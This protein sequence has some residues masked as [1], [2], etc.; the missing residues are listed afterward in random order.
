MNKKFYR[1]KFNAK[2]GTYVA[3]S[4]LAK[5]HQ[6]DTSPRIKSSIQNNVRDLSIAAIE[7]KQEKRTL[8]QLVLALSTLMAVSPIYANVVVNN[9]AAAAHKGTVL[10]AGNAANVWI[11]APSASGV[12][13]NSYTQFDVNQNGVILNN[14]RGAATSQITKTSIAA[15]P[16][17][18]KGAAT[19]IVNEVISTNPSLLQGNLEVLGSKANVVIA[20][21][22]GITVNGGGFINANQVTLSTGA[23]AYNSDGSIKQHTVKQGA[24]TINPDAN[25]RGLGGNANN[26]V[27]LELLGRSIA[28][29]APVNATTINAVTGAN[30]IAADTGAFTTTT[31]TGTKPTVAI[32]VAQLG[33][34]Y[35]NS[36]YLYANEAGVGV[37]NAGII[38]AQN[39]VVLN[40]N[41]KITNTAT[42]TISST[43]KTQGLVS[44]STAGTGV[45]GD[46]NSSGSINSNSVINIDS[47]NDLNVN[48]KEIKI[49]KDGV[50]SSPLIINAKGNLNLAAN[51][52]IFNDSA[53][54]DLYIDAGNINLATNAGITSNRGSGSIQSQKDIVAAQGVK[55]IA[56]QDLNVSSKGKLALTGNVLQATVGSINLQADSSN[57]QGL[58]DVQKTSVN[59]GKDLNIYSAGDIT[60]KNLSFSLINDMTRLKNIN[61]YSEKNLVWQNEAK[62]L[63]K[64]AGKV[65]L[66]AKQGLDLSGTA[67][68]TL[69]GIVTAS[70]T[71]VLN[72]GLTSDKGIDL[73][74][75]QAVNLKYGSNLKA[76]GDI[77][78]SSLQGGIQAESLKV[79]TQGK[80]TMLAQK[81]VSLSSIQ[82]I[83]EYSY[84]GV[85]GTKTDKTLLNTNK[86]I[87]VGSVADGKVHIAAADLTS[88]NGVVALLGQNDITVTNNV[89]TQVVRE[90]SF[91][92]IVNSQFTGKSVSIE[93]KK[94]NIAVN[95]TNLTATGGNL[96]LNSVAGRL[97]VDQSTL[98]SKGNTELH[99]KDLLTLQGVTA[100]SDQHL[101]VSSGRTL[102]LNASY[103]PTT[104]VWDPAARTD[105]TAKGVLSLTATGNQVMQN[106]KLTGGAV[107][108]ETTNLFVK[109]GLVFNAVGNDLLKNDKKLNSLNGNLSIQT[110]GTTGLT[111]DP[112][113]MNLS[114]VGDIE[115]TSK[116]GALTL[117]GY[118][119]AK[120]SGSEQVV[121]LNTKTGGISLEGTQVNLQGSQLDAAKDVKIIASNGD[122]LIDG[123][124]NNFNN[125]KIN[126]LIVS[127][128]NNLTLAREEKK[129][130]DN[131]PLIITLKDEQKNQ[132]GVEETRLAS[133]PN[134]M[135]NLINSVNNKYGKITSFKIV[136]N[137]YD[138]EGIYEIFIDDAYTTK[139]NFLENELNFFGQALNGYEHHES[140]LISNNGNISLISLNGVSLSGAEVVAMQ[141]SVNIEAHGPLTQKYMTTAQKENQA[142]TI[143]ASIIIDGTQDFYDKGNEND[144]NYNF[145]TLINPSTLSG[146]KG[147]N[148]KAIGKTENDNLVLQAT[149]ITAQNG[150]VRIEAN[151]NIVFDSA[152]EQSYDRSTTSYTKKSWGGMKKK[153]VTINTENNNVDAASVDITGKNIFIESK[154]KSPN[155]SIDIYSGSFI[156]D[157]GKVSIRSGGNLNFF[158]VEESSTSKEDVT[159]KSSFA[160]IKY[161]KSKSN[162]TRTQVTEMPASL[163]ADYIG[164]KSG[165]DTRLV[166]TE[167]EYLKDATIE[168]GRKL[169]LIAAK[170]KITDIVKKESNSIV[171]QSM[172]DKGSINETAKLPS[173]NGPVAPAFIAEGGLR[174]QVPVVSGQNNDVIAEVIK[175]S[176]QPGNEYLK[177]LVARKDVNWDAV[178]LAQESWDYKSQGLTGAGA[179]I[180]AIIVVALTYG[181][182]TAAL[183]TT[184]TAAEGATTVTVA[185]T[186]FAVGAGGSVTTFGGA[187]M[188]TTVGGVSTFTATG[189]MVNAALTTMATKSSISLINNGG[190]VGKTL[191]ELGSKDSVKNLAVTL[192]TVG[193][194]QGIATNLRIS[195]DA[196]V[197]EL[198]NRMATGMIKGVGSTLIDSAINGR[199]LSE[200]LENALL[201]GLANSLQAPLAG[202][203]GDT[204][205][206]SD[207]AFVSKV[208]AIA[209]HAAASCATGLLD[210][211]CQSRALGAALGEVI[212]EN[213]FKPANGVEYTAAE[214]ARILTVS[215]LT[216]GVVAAYT[217]YD[218]NAAA[219][220]ADI[221]VTNNYLSHAQEKIKN[222]E[223]KDCKGVAC[224][225]VVLKWAAIDAGQDAMYAKGLVQGI[226]AGLLDS[227]TDL[228]KMGL[229]P[230]ETYNAMRDILGSENALGN[231]TQTVF[232]NYKDKID[233]AEAEYQKAGVKGSYNAGLEDGKL[234]FDFASLFAGIG[235]LAKGGVVLTEK[236]AARVIA[237]E[238]ITVNAQTGLK[239]F[240]VIKTPR[241]GQGRLN[242]L[243][244]GGSGKLSPVEAA[245]GAQLEN[246]LGKMKRYEPKAGEATKVSPDFEILS[247]S[248]KGK[249]VDF[250]YTTNELLPKEIEMLNKFYA[251]NMST[252]VGKKGILDHIDKA[253]FVPVDFRVLSLENQ[254]VFLGYVKTLSKT[255]QAKF[256]ILR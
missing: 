43:S 56:A 211:Q 52:Q 85:P 71:L 113:I 60:L 24:I 171:W 185:G 223:I 28:I 92:E 183:G 155:T 134:Y 160:G 36:I 17:L 34:L 256:I 232:Q 144:Q 231:I 23:L 245:A 238:R 109:P 74:A 97:G 133:G 164:T 13:R 241:E 196:A 33:G 119:G 166:G 51:S 149:K 237:A 218:V 158:T 184:I 112:K 145:K 108:L 253:D 105:L 84:R 65:Q 94:G 49:N 104:T 170:S 81:D 187:L 163:K 191:K 192:A 42:G 178:K 90:D 76:I 200:G 82:N 199:N 209:A 174:V 70:G 111:I 150:D 68:N 45:A 198:A 201:A 203:I 67:I 7:L 233:K 21:P 216:T 69:D 103:T 213:M 250:M 252:V 230:I 153:K 208:V 139:V 25:K 240:K 66:D 77:T 251:K 161:N 131:D 1:T 157:G 126:D 61:V 220:A 80:L 86:G 188:S 47:S 73:T 10:K 78:V 193:L 27:A 125:Y 254:A 248:N 18:A 205:G 54:G 154:E 22:S 98:K 63:P 159:K 14:S 236:V 48:A 255:Q 197:N 206:M 172:Q 40:S 162:A 95:N 15:N 135:T 247:G 44:I 30:T 207:N 58:V 114:A 141:G 121:K 239:E 169:E 142:N 75:Y 102:Y 147:V 156:A 110:T 189:A 167:F 242:T 93:N 101:A 35:A 123:V 204:L 9:N 59:A 244:V 12:S 46:I 87:V 219:N 195:S 8:T 106:A 226:P 151:K 55:L 64:I 128:A 117:V 130:F 175:L 91:D 132:W 41:G 165:F 37:N 179:A 176:N 31:G 72:S 11:T 143:G 3:V 249:T 215:K 243:D 62:L 57:I 235:G 20:N 221:A 120:G 152:V 39:N 16:N 136:P 224:S 50:I 5:S 38:R 214:K 229:N 194:L 225:G 146:N 246:V 137:S 53:S 116:K 83:T 168:S 186:T 228:L 210:N 88:K 2:L 122:V 180:I 127:L 217:G 79:D 227:A 140:S 129:K 182:G 212:A 26:P 29:N 99:A 234:I 100:T 202:T 115:L 181:A 96:S 124:K 32:D 173:F 19:T 89:D 4:E 148:I 118:G 6:G 138:R 190:D 177:D 107:L 222:Q